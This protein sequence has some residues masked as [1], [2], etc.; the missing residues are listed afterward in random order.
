MTTSAVKSAMFNVVKALGYA[1]PPTTTY[2]ESTHQPTTG[3]GLFEASEGED[4]LDKAL[5]AT[6][7]PPRTAEGGRF[8]LHKDLKYVEGACVDLTWCT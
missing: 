6:P 1:P 2:T 7:P 4:E 3:G 5:A 8:T